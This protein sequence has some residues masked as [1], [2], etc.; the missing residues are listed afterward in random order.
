MATIVGKRGPSIRGDRGHDLS[1]K[2]PRSRFD[3]TAI[4]EFFHEASSP[5]DR[6]QVSDGPDHRRSILLMHD[7]RLCDADPTF[8]CVDKVRER[9]GASWPS[10]RDHP[11]ITTMLFCRQF[12]EDQTVQRVPHIAKVRRRSRIIVVV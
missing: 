4:V 6:D 1:P 7:R 10:D 12:D 2:V 5:S 11:A 3:H 9:S 8:R